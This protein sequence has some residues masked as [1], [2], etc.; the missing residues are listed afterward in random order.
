MKKYY[1]VKVGY[2]KNEFISIQE[3]EL[4][5]AIYAFETNV[6]AKF[7]NGVVRGQ[8]II[9]ITPDYHKALGCNNAEYEFNS[10]DWA[11]LAQSGLKKP[12]LE[13]YKLASM[14]VDYLIEHKQE[15]L[16]GKNVEI[17]EL[18]IKSELDIKKVVEKSLTINK[19][20]LCQDF[21]KQ[22]KS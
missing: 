12:L 8:D 18:D 16:I 5:K 1:R 14:R 9:A 10:Y 6:K 13:T 22:N 19:N 21:Q 4:E 2:G 3:N 11:E 20:H 7:D 15:N 17:P